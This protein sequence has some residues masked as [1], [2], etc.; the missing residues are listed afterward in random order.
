MGLEWGPLSFMSTLEE[1]L[2]RK[3]SGSVQ[4]AGNTAVGICLSAEDGTN[5]VNKWGSLGIVLSRT[6]ATEF[7]FCFM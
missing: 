4:K 1:L 6:Q 7:N 2:E 3:S 5:F